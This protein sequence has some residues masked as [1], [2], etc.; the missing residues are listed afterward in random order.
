MAARTLELLETL[1]AGEEMTSEM[2]E[3]LLK[4][5]VAEDLYLEYKHGDELKESKKAN[6]TVRQYASGFANSAG[7]ILLCGVDEATWTV[8]G[9]SLPGGGSLTEWASRSLTNIAA[10]LSP[11]AR[12]CT[13][14]HPDGKVLVI[15]TARTPGLVPITE[16]SGLVYYFRFHDQTLNNQTLKAPDYLIS[17][18]VLGRRQRPS[19]YIA[20]SEIF[21]AR[22]VGDRVSIDRPIDISFEVNFRVENRS[23]FWAEDVRL[24]IISLTKQ[25]QQH[26]LPPGLSG[27][28]LP[29]GNELRL[30]FDEQIIDKSW[31]SEPVEL[32]HYGIYNSSQDRS[33]TPYGVGLFGSQ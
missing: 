31:Y 2:L 25:H 16:A 8:T 3:D 19:L 7:G 5:R 26:Q 20:E 24:G 21:G 1:L 30:Y 13:I 18:I 22:E 33:L 10:Y 14:N 15:A 23:L 17:D 28:K 27:R 6:A 29:I 11:P 9:C 4:N 32:S 12:F